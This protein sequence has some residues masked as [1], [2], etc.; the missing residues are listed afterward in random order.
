[1]NLAELKMAMLGAA[2]DLT[3]RE[4]ELCRLDSH[5]GD[6]DHGISV[7]KGFNSVIKM[8]ETDT[9]ADMRDFLFES[10]LA[11]S[12]WAGGAMGPIMASLFYGMAEAIDAGQTE[13][14]AAGLY[15]AFSNGM[16]QIQELGKAEIGDRTLLDALN[17]A[18]ETLRANL[19]DPVPAALAKMA[20]SA[21]EGAQS[22][23][24]MVAKTGRARYLGEASKGY[25]DAGSMSMYYFLRAF[26]NSMKS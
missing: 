7:K 18:L 4:E 19:N 24:E 23:K 20:D 17:P 11:F 2:R 22:T 10:G 1:M 25:I 21:Y 9:T 6:G 5:V 26:A 3:G 14:D 15:R 13:I 12:D 8:M 16:A